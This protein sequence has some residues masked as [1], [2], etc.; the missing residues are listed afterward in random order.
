MIAFGFGNIPVDVQSSHLSMAR[1]AQYFWPGMSSVKPSVAP[2]CLPSSSLKLAVAPSTRVKPSVA[3]DLDLV[4]GTEVENKDNLFWKWPHLQTWSELVRLEPQCEEVEHEDNLFWKWPHLQKWSESKLDRLE[5]QC[6]EVEYKDNPELAPLESQRQE[7]R[8]EFET[9]MVEEEEEDV[10][11]ANF[12]AWKWNTFDEKKDDY[13]EKRE[14]KLS[15]RW[16]RSCR[17]KAR[18]QKRQSSS[19]RTKKRC[20]KV[21]ISSRTSIDAMVN[22]SLLR[23]SQL[24]CKDHFQCGRPVLNLVQDLLDANVRLSAPF[25]RLT[26]FDTIDPKTN[27]R[28]LRCI[29]NRR[30]FALNEFAKISGKERMMVHVKLHDLNTCTVKMVQRFMWNSDATTGLTINLRV[31]EKRNNRRRNRS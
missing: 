9:V 7:D 28:I 19:K 8:D 1:M 21:E 17:R 13:H 12:N 22:I 18:E 15:H 25:L 2:R 5:S 14:R 16:R 26:V 30:L 3:P 11:V 29:D 31:A 10:D 20:E 24:S 23:Y 27:Q 6:E 4:L